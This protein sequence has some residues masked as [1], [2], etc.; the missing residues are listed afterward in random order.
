MSTDQN[1]ELKHHCADFKEVRK[2]LVKLGATKDVTKKQK[3]YFFNLPIEKKKQNRQE[4]R[5]S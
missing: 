4:N 3:D 5:Q 1:L 2:V